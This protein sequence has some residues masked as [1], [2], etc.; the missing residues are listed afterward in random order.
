M[1][2]GLRFPHWALG[3]GRWA[4]E[5]VFPPFRAALRPP[6]GQFHAS[7]RIFIFTRPRRALIQHHRDIAAERGLNFHRN[8]RRNKSRRPINMIL[9]MHAFFGNLAQLR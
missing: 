2:D 6:D 9:E 1:V 5:V 4:F 3:V 8:F 7:R